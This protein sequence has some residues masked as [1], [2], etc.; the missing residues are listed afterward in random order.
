MSYRFLT[1]RG[2][3]ALH[4]QQIAEHGG[5]FGLRDQGLLELTLAKAQNLLFYVSQSTVWDLAAAYSYGFIQNHVFID[6]NKRVG[7]AA[8]AAFLYL[9]GY[10]MISTEAAEVTVVLAV[11]TGKTTQLELA[12]WSERFTVKL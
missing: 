2:V 8:A 5:T 1:K 3:L 6:G 7:L 9:N 10:E 12:T 4:H 11:A